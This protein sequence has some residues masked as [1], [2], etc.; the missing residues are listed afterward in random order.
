[1]VLILSQLQCNMQSAHLLLLP[2]QMSVAA[3][4]KSHPG[5]S[6]TAMLAQSSSE[7]TRGKLQSVLHSVTYMTALVVYLTA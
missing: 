3:A 4:C 5:L 7:Q 1:M 6:M 2:S